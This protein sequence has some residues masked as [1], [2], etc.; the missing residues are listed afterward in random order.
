MQVWLVRHAVAVERHLDLAADFD[1]PLT[2]KGRRRFRRFARWLADRPA[3]PSAVA[4]SP[5]VRA[6]QTAAIL[7]EALG[8]KESDLRIEKCLAPGV[9]IRR[10]ISLLKK[11]RAETIAVVG[12]EPDM[13]CLAAKFIGG[14]SLTFGKGNIACIE[15]DGN[16]APGAGS[17]RWFLGPR[18]IID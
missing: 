15:F 3:P 8:F 2:A 17:L 5:L 12:H 7:N 10:L 16:P 11:V 9:D 4:A 14:G 6:V 18:L 1:R 13:S